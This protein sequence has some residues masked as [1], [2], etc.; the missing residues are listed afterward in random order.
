MLCLSCEKAK[1]GGVNPKVEALRELSFNLPVKPL[2]STLP[3]SLLF[4]PMPDFA[5]LALSVAMVIGPI[6]GY[7]DQVNKMQTLPTLS[8]YAHAKK[9]STLLSV[10]S[11]RVPGSIP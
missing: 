5:Q 2:L 10:V 9:H 7:I 3:L 11:N 1:M 4:L 6:V 8:S